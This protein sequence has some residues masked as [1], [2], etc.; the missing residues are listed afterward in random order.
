[1]FMFNE[2]RLWL[3]F[4]CLIFSCLLIYYRWHRVIFTTT[5]Q[6][7]WFSWIHQNIC[8]TFKLFDTRMPHSFI[9]IEYNLGLLVVRG[10]VL[11]ICWS[12]WKAFLYGPINDFIIWLIDDIIQCCFYS[13][14]FP[15]QN[16]K[17][18]KFSETSFTVN[19]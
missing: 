15:A 13:Y 18:L 6:S 17:L 16:L 14:I 19:R 11:M 10:Y 3:Y 4:L 5:M 1:M 8:L 2:A 12:I 9:T 7:F